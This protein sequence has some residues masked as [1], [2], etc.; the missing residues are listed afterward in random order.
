MRILITT[1]RELA[2]VSLSGLCSVIVRLP[3]NIEGL[4]RLR[5]A[6][7]INIRDMAACDLA[8]D[9]GLKFSVESQFIA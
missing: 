1:L 9:L 7:S 3:V 4:L 5:R 2:I 6:L 8:L